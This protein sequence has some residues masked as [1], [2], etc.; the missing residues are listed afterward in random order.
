MTA[1]R[2]QLRECRHVLAGF[3]LAPLG[4]VPACL[5]TP[6]G[7]S[8]SNFT[9]EVSLTLLYFISRLSKRKCRPEFEGVGVGP[10]V[11][12]EAGGFLQVRTEGV[13]SGP[14]WSLGRSR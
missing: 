12:A 5:M 1:A 4:N 2:R 8:R 10:A 6:W 9:E 7:G 11:A 3:A 14:R 13:G